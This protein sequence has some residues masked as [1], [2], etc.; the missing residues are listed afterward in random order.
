MTDSDGEVNARLRGVVVVM[1]GKAD[2]GGKSKVDE[3]REHQRGSSGRKREARQCV[4]ARGER[5][6]ERW[7]EGLGRFL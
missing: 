7:F 6:K 4:R 3:V 1:M 5:W 2:R